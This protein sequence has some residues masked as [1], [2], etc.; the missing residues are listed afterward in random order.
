MVEQEVQ[1][2]VNLYIVATVAIVYYD[3]IMI[4]QSATTHV[5]GTNKIMV[6]LRW[7]APS[8]G[9]GTISFRYS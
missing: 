5:D 7:T 1:V 2:N 9:T 6:E 3:G 8:M 4:V